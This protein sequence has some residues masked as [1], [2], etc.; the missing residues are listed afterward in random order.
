[1]EPP[2]ARASPRRL[3]QPRLPDRDRED[4][5]LRADSVRD[6]HRA[7]G[8]ARRCLHPAGPEFRWPLATELATD[9][10]PKGLRHDRGYAGSGGGSRARTARGGP[11]SDRSRL[12]GALGAPDDLERP[13]RGLSLRDLRGWWLL[14]PGREPD[15]AQRSRVRH[16]PHR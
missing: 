16:R 5:A 6:R 9:E 1:S 13:G 4:T 3:A 8:L 10:Q 11:E 15:A 2:R 14:E 7:R 12:G